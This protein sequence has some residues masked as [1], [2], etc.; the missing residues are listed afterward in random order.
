VIIPSSV[1]DELNNLASRDKA[2]AWINSAIKL[3]GKF[4]TEIVQGKGDDAIF[5]LACKYKAIVL[6]NDKELKKRLKSEGLQTIY[7]KSKTHLMLD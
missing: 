6:T 7:L 2:P 3:A 4:K 5:D 1:L